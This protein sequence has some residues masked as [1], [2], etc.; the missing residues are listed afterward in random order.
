MPITERDNEDGS[1]DFSNRA[2]PISN[3]HLSKLSKSD[4]ESSS[5]SPV[6]SVAQSS[7]GSGSDYLDSDLVTAAIERL[8]FED[9]QVI[10]ALF[11][12][13]VLE[14]HLLSDKNVLIM[15]MILSSNLSVISSNFHPIVIIF[16]KL[17]G[18]PF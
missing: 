4:G 14:F 2:R 7:L 18:I 11:H 1:S 6:S 15:D 16:C 8:N 17:S 3:P 13:G 5:N 10:F 9:S 12:V